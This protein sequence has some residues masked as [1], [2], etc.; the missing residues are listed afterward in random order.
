MIKPNVKVK[1]KRFNPFYDRGCFPKW[2][3]LDMCSDC[4]KPFEFKFYPFN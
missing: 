1:L 4:N 3:T 2:E